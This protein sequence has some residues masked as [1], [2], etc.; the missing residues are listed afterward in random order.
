[1][2]AEFICWLKNKVRPHPQVPLGIGDDAAILASDD[3]HEWVVTTDMLMDG[4]DFRLG[5]VDPRRIGRKALAVNLSDLAAMGATPVCAFVSI[6]VPQQGALELSKQL[7]E[8]MIELANAVKVTI[9]GGDTNTWEGPL[10]ISVTAMGT[11]KRGRAWRR[12]GALPGDVVVVTGEFGGSILGRHLDGGFCYDEAM[13]WSGEFQIHAAM[14]VSDGL[15]LDLSRLAEA[16][17]CG[18]EIDLEKVP[19]AAEARQLAASTGRTPLDHALGDGEDF[20]LILALSPHEAER[21]VKW[22]EEWG[23]TYELRTPT[24]IG[25]FIPEPGLWTRDAAGNRIP[26]PPRG[27]LHESK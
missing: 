18:A 8:G 6:A 11:V 25:R 20:E 26:L 13:W 14:D 12:A 10:V 9:A 4:V 22:C 21:L 5:E 27:Y 3:Q 23:N 17:R 19:I 15:S 1:M 24:I 7:Y 2:E 16:S